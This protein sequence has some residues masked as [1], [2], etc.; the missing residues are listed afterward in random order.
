MCMYVIIFCFQLWLFSTVSAIVLNIMHY[1]WF[2]IIQFNVICV[3]VCY[4]SNVSSIVPIWEFCTGS[5]MLRLYLHNTKTSRLKVKHPVNRD[6]VSKYL[7]AWQWE[8]EMFRWWMLLF[9]FHLAILASCRQSLW[10]SALMIKWF[11]VLDL[12]LSPPT[13]R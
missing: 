3:C 6:V 11:Q 10:Q 9:T 7:Q 8:R 1:S 5:Y 4:F 13:G 2:K 12:V